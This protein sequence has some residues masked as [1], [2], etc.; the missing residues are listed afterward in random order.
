MS[1]TT[2]TTPTS[3]PR[4]LASGSWVFVAEDGRATLISSDEAMFLLD[5]DEGPT[6]SLCDALGHGYPG[7][8]PCPLEE[9]GAYA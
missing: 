6:C 3:G 4:Q 1:A 5:A 2:I 8:G 7:A 9:R